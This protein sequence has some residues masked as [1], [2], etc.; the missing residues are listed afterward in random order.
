[1][2][3]VTTTNRCGPTRREML[4]VGFLGLGGLTLGDLLRL[5]AASPTPRNDRA[6]IVLWVHGGPSHLETYDLK[7]DAPTDTRSIFKP[8]RT[9]APGLDV[10]EYLPKHAAIA[11]KFTLLRS[12]AHDE[13]DHGFGTRRFVTGYGKDVGGNGKSYYPSLECVAYRTLGGLRDG[14]PVSMNVGPFRAST[15]WRGAGYFGQKHEVPET[16]VHPLNG[17][18]QGLQEAVLTA[19]PPRFADRRGLLTQFDQLQRGLDATGAMDAMDDFQRQAFQVLTSPSA[20]RA[21]DLTREPDKVRQRYD[22]AGFA[23]DVLLARRLVEAGVNFVN[24]YISGQPYGTKSSAYNWDDHAVNWDMA[25]AMKGRLPW[26]D[27]L[28]TTLIEDLHERGLDEKVLLLVTGEFGR[29]PRLER[30]ANGNI[31]RDHWPSA[32]SILVAGGGRRRGDVMGATNSRGEHPKTQRFD[33]HDLLAT[34]YQYL[35]IDYRMEF[36]DLTGRPIALSRGTPIDGLI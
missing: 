21:F 25:A 33:P 27:H 15:P 17:L 7:P 8:I 16:Y 6:V 9:K 26:Y 19:D 34:V 14:L 11:D 2:L 4:R 20:R 36:S 32:M 31:G 18:A 24:V 1:M 29:T 13:A 30:Q 12:V 23:Q 22:A 5:R 28:V 3:R 35:G 10:C